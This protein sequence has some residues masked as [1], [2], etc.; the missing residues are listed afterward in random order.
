MKR[1]FGGGGAA[2]PGD[3]PLPKHFRWHSVSERYFVPRLVGASLPYNPR[4]LVSV[5]VEWLASQMFRV[6]SL[7][8]RSFTEGTGDVRRL[9]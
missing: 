1:R 2:R 9:L 5:G 7:A 4:K 3:F 6:T 8:L